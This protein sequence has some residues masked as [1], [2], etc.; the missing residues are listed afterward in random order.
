[1][2]GP[3]L[4]VARFRGSRY[5]SRPVL[6]WTRGSWRPDPVT[7]EKVELPTWPTRD[8]QSRLIEYRHGGVRC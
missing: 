7:G 2:L 3:Q 4:P 6:R 1:M 8:E 5:S